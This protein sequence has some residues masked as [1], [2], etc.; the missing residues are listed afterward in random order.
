MPRDSV[1]IGHDYWLK[2]IDTKNFDYSTALKTVAKNM[3]R[4][5]HPMKPF[6]DLGKGVRSRYKRQAH[7]TLIYHG[8]TD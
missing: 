2:F 8:L 6:D 3:A 1:R 7:D 4:I 5:D